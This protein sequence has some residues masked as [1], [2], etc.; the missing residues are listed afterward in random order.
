MCHEIFS[1]CLSLLDLFLQA[2]FSSHVGSMHV[3][4][5][6]GLCYVHAN[7]QHARGF[8]VTAWS[9][10]ISS[11]PA[12]YHEHTT[13]SRLCSPTALFTMSMAMHSC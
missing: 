12:A 3:D 6:S 9:C 4:P 1:I 13:L 5:S 2:T 7:V 10:T 11:L 8:S